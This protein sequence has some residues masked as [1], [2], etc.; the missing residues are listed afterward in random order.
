M[1]Q[2]S[3]LKQWWLICFWF[4]S[5]KLFRTWQGSRMLKR[6]SD[7]RRQCKPINTRGVNHDYNKFWLAL[8]DRRW[9][10]KKKIYSFYIY[11][12]GPTKNISLSLKVLL[13]LRYF[14]F[15]HITWKVWNITLNRDFN[16]C[17]IIF[18]NFN[19]QVY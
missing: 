5:S 12:T 8:Q 16:L 2:I 11:Y 6:S 3:N 19:S 17:F 15:L 10:K 9:G 13:V 18:R 1:F 4:T 14:L 7:A